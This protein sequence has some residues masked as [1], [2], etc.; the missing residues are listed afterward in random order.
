MATTT[1]T[2]PTSCCAIAIAESKGTGPAVLLIHGNSSCKEVFRNQLEGE[3]GR[4]YRMIALDLPGHGASEDAP[5]PEHTYTMPGYAEVAVEVLKACEVDSAAVLGW[6]LGGHI[7]LEVIS[8]FPG[9]KGL[10]ITGT[11]P[12]GPDDLGEGFLPNPH[13][14]LA[15]QEVFSDAEADSF[16]HNTCGMNAPFEPFLLDAVRRC[17]GRARRIMFSSFG[18]GVGDNQRTIV[19]TSTVPLANVSG[20]AEPYVNNAYLET[21][22]YANLWEGKVHL[23]DGL[24]H[25]PFWEAPGQFDPIL[26][27]FL[28]DVLD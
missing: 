26:A 16:A 1:C 24:G 6:S 19:E 17:D 9:L 15:S 8:R 27:R 21:I 12:V 7:G 25:A 28:G 14:H 18:G 23:L 3:L 11:P 22:A 5:E 4:R 13:M 2:V 10:M 20:G